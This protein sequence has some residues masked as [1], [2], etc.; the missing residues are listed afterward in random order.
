MPHLSLSTNPVE[1]KAPVVTTRAACEWCMLKYH[2]SGRPCV[3]RR[4]LQHQKQSEFHCPPG[5]RARQTCYGQSL[6]FIVFH[7]VLLL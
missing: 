2:C 3:S 5:S 4:E 7:D 1:R 6:M